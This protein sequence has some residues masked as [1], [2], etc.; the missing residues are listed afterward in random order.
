MRDT[1]AFIVGL[2]ALSTGCAS[3]VTGGKQ[4]ITVNSNVPGAA[5]AVNG[6][7][8]GVT[9]F[10]G[11]VKRDST[12]HL[13]V[14][15]PGYNPQSIVLTTTLEPWFWGNIILGGFF[16]S[17]TDAGTGAMNKY[18]PDTYVVTLVPSGPPP[19]AASPFDAPAG[20]PPGAPPAM[21]PAAA[22]A[23]SP[24]APAGK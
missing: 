19:V 1:A 11:E 3:I 23:P 18:A 21:V 15:K 12:A 5:V 13:T 10:V 9:P 4:P 24:P 20:A 2:V 22:T 17:S 16:G 7:Q 14:S 6:Q 8:V